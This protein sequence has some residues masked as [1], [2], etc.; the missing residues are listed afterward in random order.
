[1]CQVRHTRPH[2]GIGL[3]HSKIRQVSS[4]GG[5]CER[6]KQAVLKTAVPERVPGVRIPL[7]PPASLNS[8]E[9][10]RFPSENLRKPRN[11]AWFARLGRTESQSDSAHPP[12]ECNAVPVSAQPHRNCTWRVSMI[13]YRDVL[14]FGGSLIR[15]VSL[16]PLVVCVTLSVCSWG[17]AAPAAQSSPKPSPAAT[18]QR[19]SASSSEHGWVAISNHYADMLIQVSFKFHPE[20]A[21]AQGL[22]QFDDKVSQPTL[23]NERAERREIASV[24]EKLKAA[25][26]EKQQQDVAEDLQIMIRRVNLNSRREDF[27]LAYEVPYIN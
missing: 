23:A 20:Q 21:S 5:M 22:S 15:K 19:D 11:S 10:L 18:A 13:Y 27:Q 26:A 3:D 14:R 4:C 25:S 17:Q 8:R 6:L 12:G 2:I 9:T 16:F 24:L 1:M 7:P